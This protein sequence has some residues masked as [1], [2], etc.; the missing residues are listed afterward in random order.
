MGCGATEATCLGKH[1]GLLGL[2]LFGMFSLLSILDCLALF[3]LL[4]LAYSAYWIPFFFHK[5]PFTPP[6][7]TKLSKIRASYLEMMKGKDPEKKQVS[8]YSKLC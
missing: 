1:I 8:G 7:Q 2:C 5:F 6:P 4:C 3:V